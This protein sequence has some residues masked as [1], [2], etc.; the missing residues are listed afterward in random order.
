[1]LDPAHV[2]GDAVEPHRVDAV[3]VAALDMAN[4]AGRGAVSSSKRNELEQRAKGF[5]TGCVEVSSAKNISRLRS[6]ESRA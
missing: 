5:C 3:I 4:G 1:M 6:F 2:L